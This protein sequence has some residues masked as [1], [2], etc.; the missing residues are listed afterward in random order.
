[1]TED[2]SSSQREPPDDG[3]RQLLESGAQLLRSI[4]FLCLLNSSA[5]TTFADAI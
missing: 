4:D 1:M 5:V 3:P 2:A